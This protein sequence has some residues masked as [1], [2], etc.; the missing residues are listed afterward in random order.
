MDDAELRRLMDIS[1]KQRGGKPT[2]YPLL[3]PVTGELEQL[4][5]NNVSL[6]VIRDWLEE[7]K[8]ISV[9]LNTLRKF[10]ILKV[11]RE[12]YDAYLLR[13]GWAK[14]IHGKRISKQAKPATS[15]P[16]SAS[17]AN[18][19]DAQNVMAGLSSTKK[20][21]EHDPRANV[22]NLLEIDDDQKG[23]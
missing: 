7:K 21:G 22:K 20:P 1:Q 15:K 12:K 17:P 14:N 9:V 4:I 6:V 13:N 8:G 3:D 10:I 19:G 2:K 11:G 23:T 16:A 18:V 5:E